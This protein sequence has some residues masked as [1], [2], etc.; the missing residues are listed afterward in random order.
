[1]GTYTRQA[2]R[3]GSTAA[4]NRADS[5]V[6]RSITATV[7]VTT[8]THTGI[9]GTGIAKLADT[10]AKATTRAGLRAGRGHSGSVIVVELLTSPAP[11][12]PRL[13]R[14]TPLSED[15]E[16]SQWPDHDQNPDPVRHTVPILPEL[17]SSPAT[18]P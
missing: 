13:L 6:T 10:T 5:A 16:C 11:V 9:S 17:G 14:G 7:T 12:S 4:P 18:P 1:M 2:W 15:Q 3:S 8:G